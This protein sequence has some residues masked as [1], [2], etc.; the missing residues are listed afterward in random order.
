MESS[1]PEILSS[2]SYIL[3]VMLVSMAPDL[4]PMFSISR[5]VSLCDSFI[6][7]T[8]TF[9]SWMVLLNS[10]T[11]LDVFSYNYIRDFCVSSLRVST[12]LHVFSCVSIKELFM[13]FLKSSINITRSDF[14]SIS[15]FSGLMVCPGLTMVEELS[16]G[17][18]N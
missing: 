8:S 6:V 13:S 3:S 9:R 14:R 10:F 16:S 11:S 7:S 4:F 15:C 2:I 18:A 1:A 17:D 5:V 12:C